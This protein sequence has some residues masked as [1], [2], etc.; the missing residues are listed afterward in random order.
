MVQPQST[1][2]LQLTQLQAIGHTLLTPPPQSLQDAVGVGRTWPGLPHWGWP[3]GTQKGRAG[4]LS[5]PDTAHSAKADNSWRM[6][7]SRGLE[8]SQGGELS[9]LRHSERPGPP[10]GR[11]LYQ[12]V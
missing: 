12:Q 5:E 11:A 1:L 4:H 7:P 6:W 2:T 10:E 3:V 8:T 9:Q